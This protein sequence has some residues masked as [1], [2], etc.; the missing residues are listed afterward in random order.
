MATKRKKLPDAS[1]TNTPCDAV[2]LLIA[3]MESNPDEFTLTKN[4]RWGDMMNMVRTRHVEHDSSHLC[5]LSDDEIKLIWDKF[6]E[7]GK[8]S[9]HNEFMRR[10]LAAGDSPNESEED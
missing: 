4:S 2:K 9:L 7:A 8:I 10:I 6:C 1:D 5:I 3:R